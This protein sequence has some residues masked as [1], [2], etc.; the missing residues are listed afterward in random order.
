[1]TDHIYLA[2][3]GIKGQKWGV[4]RFQNKDGSLTSAGRQRYAEDGTKLSFAAR[5][6]M[7]KAAKYQHFY[8]K[9]SART[10]KRNAFDKE[11]DD[12]WKEIEKKNPKYKGM[13]EKAH[14]QSV[15]RAKFR[16][17]ADN[18]WKEL[19][20]VE[21]RRAQKAQEYHDNA[22]KYWNN[23]SR[24]KKVGT[25]LLYG[26]TGAQQYV[27]AKGSGSS[28]ASAA[29]QTIVSRNLLG[30]PIGSMLVNDIRRSDYVDK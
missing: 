11:A 4:R 27:A 13:Y 15:K 10:K 8:E 24:G 9:D 28:T 1:M 7:R 25:V 19:S 3:H 17:E 30:G 14:A 21:L 20:D 18:E 5:R 22:K 6:H 23:M 16:E 26:L 12:E 2:H 29:A